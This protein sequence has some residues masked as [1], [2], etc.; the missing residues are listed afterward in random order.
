MWSAGGRA[1]GIGDAR[2]RALI[3]RTAAGVE[4]A[5]LAVAVVT[6]RVLNHR[7]GSHLRAGSHPRRWASVNS[8]P[9]RSWW[10]IR[11]A[12]GQSVSERRPRPGPWR[13]PPGS[14]LRAS[15]NGGCPDQ[16]CF[17]FSNPCEPFAI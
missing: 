5:D 1:T 3:D 12:V 14:E 2:L 6:L 17:I 16:L 10:P 7:L 11:E 8:P 13:S 4:R 9:D 15:F